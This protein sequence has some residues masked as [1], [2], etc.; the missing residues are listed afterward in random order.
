[1]KRNEISQILAKLASGEISPEQASRMLPKADDVS[2]DELDDD[3][4]TDDDEDESDEDEDDDE[5]EDWDRPGSYRT[6]VGAS[7]GQMGVAL[8]GI[9][10]LILE[11]IIATVIA[12]AIWNAGHPILAVIAWFAVMAFSNIW[13][14]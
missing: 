4:E 5:D 10:G 6:A 1:M 3:N 14:K 12:V 8:A 13:Y 2:A 9:V 11:A 7:H